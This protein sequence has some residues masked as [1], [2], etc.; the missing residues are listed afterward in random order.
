[1][2]DGTTNRLED[3]VD[4]IINERFGPDAKRHGNIDVM[5]SF[6]R[7]LVDCGG[8]RYYGLTIPYEPG[9]AIKG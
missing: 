7:V 5:D 8:P 3:L 1:M 2:T 9:E 4:A 6:Y